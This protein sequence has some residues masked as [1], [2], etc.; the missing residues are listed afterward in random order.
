MEET[1]WTT[2]NAHKYSGFEYMDEVWQL[3]VAE[4]E[5]EERGENDGSE[6]ENDL[7]DAC[8]S[9]DEADIYMEDEIG[10]D[11]AG[12]KNNPEVAGDAD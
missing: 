8:D 4:T 2:E 1:A 3:L 6:G 10:T 5:G 7:G 11:E 12:D 9:E